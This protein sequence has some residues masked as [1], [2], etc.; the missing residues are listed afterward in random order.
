MSLREILSEKSVLTVFQKFLLLEI[1]LKSKLAK[2][3]CFAL[4]I[5]VTHKLRC[6]RYAFHDCSFLP[7]RD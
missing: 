2:Y 6:F 1:K 4:Q 3:C 5:S 7:F